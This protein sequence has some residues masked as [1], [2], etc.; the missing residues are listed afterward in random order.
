MVTIKNIGAEPFA[1]TGCPLLQKGETAEV[2]SYTANMVRFN[3]NIEIISD[4]L[5]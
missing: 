5:R 2:S 3:P 4:T 1:I